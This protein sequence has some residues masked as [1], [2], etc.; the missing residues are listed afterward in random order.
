MVR[1]L[2]LNMGPILA[3]AAPRRHDLGGEKRLPP[4]FCLKR[5]EVSLAGASG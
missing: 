2:C 5:D 4:H 3:R 1:D